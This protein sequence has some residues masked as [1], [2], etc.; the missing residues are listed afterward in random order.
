[1]FIPTFC[2]H[3]TSLLALTIFLSNQLSAQSMQVSKKP[4]LSKKPLAAQKDTLYTFSEFKDVNVSDL[5]P[6]Q[7][8]AGDTIESPKDNN[9]HTPKIPRSFETKEEDKKMPENNLYVPE[10]NV[11]NVVETSFYQDSTCVDLTF[12][13]VSI[14]QITEKYV[15]IEYSIINKG[16]AP[17]SIFGEKRTN[18]DNVAVHFYFSGT[19][20]L[21][22]G[23][24]LADGIYL[25]EGLR[26]TKG[27]LAPN[28]VYKNKFKLSLDKKNRFYGVII[29]QL[30]VFDVL[31]HECD[32][33]NNIYAIVP[34]WY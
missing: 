8:I 16:T 5:L 26:E 11:Q 6:K 27:M 1:M 22:R 17:A 14:V 19:P 2:K 3:L 25:T 12:D 13:S 24:I 23:A 31:R 33:T 29:L 10:N 18:S 7:L 4:P 34:K 21:T 30:D 9:I 20:R 32:E 28:A 15:E